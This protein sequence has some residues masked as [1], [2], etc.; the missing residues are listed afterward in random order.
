M[1]KFHCTRRVH[2]HRY[3]RVL[4]RPVHF[5]H[6]SVRQRH[7]EQVAIRSGLNIGADTKAPADQKAL[8]FSD[9]ELGGIIRD[10]ILKPWIIDSDFQAVTSQI[11]ME[12]VTVR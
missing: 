11:E 6:S 4:L 2:G 1:D 9:V 5:V 12:K 3:C 8:A 7:H 10:S